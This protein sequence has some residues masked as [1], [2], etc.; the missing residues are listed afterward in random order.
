[1][2]VGITQHLDGSI[3]HLDGMQIDDDGSQGLPVSVNVGSALS[4]LQARGARSHGGTTQNKYMNFFPM[5]TS[6]IDIGL[7]EVVVPNHKQ[8]FFG[9]KDYLSLVWYLI[10][11]VVMMMRLIA[12][13]KPSISTSQKL[14]LAI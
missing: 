13:I 14:S 3:H 10:S 12:Q 5:W 2:S 1:M 8:G 4:I 9:S 6:D 11:S 7:N